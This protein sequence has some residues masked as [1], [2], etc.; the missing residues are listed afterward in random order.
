MNTDLQRTLLQLFQHVSE[1]PDSMPVVPVDAWQ[2]GSMEWQLLISFRN[3][4]ERLQQSRQ[5]VQQSEERFALA[6]QG[7]NDGLW[8]WDLRTDIVYFSPRWKSMLGYEDHEIPH[9]FNEWLKRLHPE[10]RERA[11]ETIQDYLNGRT[12]TYRLEHRLQHKD[13][14]YRWIIARGA[15]LRDKDGKPYRLAGS[16]TDITERKQ[17]EEQLREKESQYRSIFEATTDMFLIVDLEEGSIIEA[18]PAA[19][20]VYGYTYEELISQHISVTI[21]SDDRPYVMNH[22]FPLI[23]AGGEYFARG[24]GLRKDGTTF[25]LDVH[26]AGFTYQ[27]KLH[28]LAVIRDITEQVQAEEHLREK[29]AQYR[30]I[31]EATSDGLLINDLEDGHIVEANPAECKMHGCTYEELLNLPMATLI[32]PDYLPLFR[33]Y[34]QT[35][36]AGGEF[37]ARAVDLRKDGTPYPVEVRGSTFIYKG[38]PHALSVI[39]DVTEQVQA[40]EQL[41][42]KEEQYRS[43]FEA[44]TNALLISDLHGFII[45]VNPAAC[46]MYG[47]AYE[48]LVS[49]HAAALV[50][51]DIQ[52]E[53]EERLQTIQMGGQFQTQSVGVRKDGTPFHL[54]V[55]ATPFTYKGTP[56]ILGVIRDITEQVQAYELLEKR[57]EERTHELS[58]LLEVSHDVASTIELKPLL[59]L[60]LDQLKR[61]VDYTGSSFSI[62]EGE[63]LVLVENR[64]PAPLDQVL[65]LH[66]PVKTMGIIWE[67]LSRREPVIIPDVQDDSLLAQAFRTWMGKRLKIPFGYIR[68]WLAIPLSHKEQVL[69]MLTVSSREPN[70][71]TPR[72]A[73][74][75]LAIANQAAVAL[76]NARLYGQAQELAALEERQRLA[77]ELHDSVSQAL[78]GIT[79]GTHTARTLL[80][81]DPSR[82]AEPLDYVLSQAE[83][84]LIEM[85]ALIFELRPESL[86]T[87]GLVAALSRQAAAL[88]ARHEMEVS[89]EF[90]DEPDLPLKVKEELY[91][92][93]QEALHNTAKHARANKVNLRMRVDTEG[94]LLEVC[95]DG[96]GFD[97]THSFPGHLGL[98]SMRERIARLSG[99]LQIESRPGK[100]TCIRA[101]L[102]AP[103]RR[104]AQLLL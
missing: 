37:Q 68:A 66:F 42:E 103:T 80:E 85:R 12:A 84:A 47:Y 41:R 58:T 44:T 50:H 20:K 27:G 45:E 93:A 36:K 19:C 38:K 86:E 61:V 1:N 33:E 31:F 74:L 52:H 2:E 6:V 7:A 14:T 24:I 53:I 59:V 98:H 100:G 72:H 63:D 56:H 71:Y 97:T 5:D 4:L 28:L 73:S 54:E 26:N 35:V 13:G 82:V 17:A 67:M 51:P 16:H 10:D 23:K 57:V 77:R 96:V 15:L 11:Q 39:R 22:V 75:A 88:H 87:E 90:C 94:V 95:D 92:V 91:R 78:Y 81:R 79:L 55:R 70:H 29:E 43:I 83:A 64:G 34:I 65:Q 8:D 9:H 101:Q 104:T 48:E 49:L 102:P 76:E 25:H 40:E 3:V 46:E 60:V 18:N 32:H 99:T 21:H 69:G 89:T 30:S 62:L